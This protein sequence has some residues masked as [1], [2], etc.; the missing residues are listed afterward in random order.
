MEDC[1]IYSRSIFHFSGRSCKNTSKF[2]TEATR[3]MM[4]YYSKKGELCGLK[5]NG[6]RRKHLRDKGM[7]E[8]LLEES[9]LRKEK[10][11]LEILNQKIQAYKDAVSAGLYEDVEEAKK[12]I[13]L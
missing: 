8:S 2:V 10:L 9:D 4:E 12:P 5:A 6:E 11:R 3:P 7:E 1:S 13:G